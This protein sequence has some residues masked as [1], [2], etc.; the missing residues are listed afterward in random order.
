MDDDNLCDLFFLDIFLIQKRAKRRFVIP[1]YGRAPWL[2]VQ[3]VDEKLRIAGASVAMAIAPVSLDGGGAG[4][5]RSI[6]DEIINIEE[7]M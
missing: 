6:V 3:S 2:W 7:I 4:R 1:G 5:D